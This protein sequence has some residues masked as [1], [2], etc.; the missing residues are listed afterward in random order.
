MDIGQP[1]EV[2][3]CNIKRSSSGKSANSVIARTKV[4]PPRVSILKMISGGSDFF[5]KYGQEFSCGLL[6]LEAAEPPST[7]IDFKLSKII[8]RNHR[9]TGCSRVCK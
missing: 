5:N 6:K 3:K 4:N 9:I 7:V 1:I 2:P 8:L